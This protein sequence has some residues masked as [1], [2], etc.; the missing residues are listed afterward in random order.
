MRFVDKKGDRT[1]LSANASTRCSQSDYEELATW[2]LQVG[3]HI[4]REDIPHKSR[5]HPDRRIPKPLVIGLGVQEELRHPVAIPL[6]KATEPLLDD[7]R[8]QHHSYDFD[9]PGDI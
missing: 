4:R 6:Q 7:H 9:P 3:W 8:P 2:D 1:D 5:Q